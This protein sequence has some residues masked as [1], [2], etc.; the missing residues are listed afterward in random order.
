MNFLCKMLKVRL[1]YLLKASYEES[2]R[3]NFIYLSVVS[4]WAHISVPNGKKDVS[5]REHFYIIC[6]KWNRNVIISSLNIRPRHS[7]F[8]INGWGVKPT[9]LQKLILQYKYYCTSTCVSFALSAV[10]LFKSNF[11]LLTIRMNIKEYFASVL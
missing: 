6:N 3:E 10:K 7:I 8:Q 9:A 11:W 1:R 2:Y 5:E 4:F